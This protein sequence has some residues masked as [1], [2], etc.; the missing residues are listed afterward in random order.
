MTTT[1]DHAPEPTVTLH[2]APRK[3]EEELALECAR[4]VAKLFR[5]EGYTVHS[6]E[7]HVRET[8]KRSLAWAQTICGGST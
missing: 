2:K 8:P 6:V 5:D 1:P 7:I 3:P 4:V